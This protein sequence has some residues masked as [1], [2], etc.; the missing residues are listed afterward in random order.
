M[1]RWDEVREGI[2]KFEESPVLNEDLLK[3]MDHV[4]LVD[5]W[6]RRAE[7]EREL[8]GTL[9]HHL[10]G[11]ERDWHQER[12]RNEELERSFEDKRRIW[13]KERE[14]LEERIK[15]REKEIELL[16]E[17]ADWENKFQEAVKKLNRGEGGRRLDS[18]EDGDD[19]F[20]SHELRRVVKEVL[21]LRDTLDQV[22]TATGWLDRE[23]SRFMD[24]L[25]QRGDT[26]R[27]QDVTQMKEVIDK[28]ATQISS[29]KEEMVKKMA[30]G[31]P[32][33]TAAP[34]VKGDTLLMGGV[35][36]QSPIAGVFKK[37]L[38]RLMDFN[39]SQE[40]TARGFC[41]K[42][43]NLL[44]II[45]GTA[46]IGLTDEKIAP[47]MKENLTTIDQN[48]T[49]LL[50]SIEEFLGITKYPQ[51]NFEEVDLNLFVQESSGPGVR[52]ELGSGLP[53]VKVDKNLI[54]DAFTCVVTNARESGA[55]DGSPVVISTTNDEA[56]N[57]VMISVKDSGKGIAENH[58]KKVFQ[59]Y[60]TTKKDQR[61]L[62]LSKARHLISL[63]GG[64]ITIES[65]KGQGTT[66][67]MWIPVS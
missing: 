11:R 12:A 40:D 54:R 51:M 42:A 8:L 38:E 44:G 67:K 30:E 23:K 1:D 61:G 17:R 33:K 4:S 16:R 7:E 10:D 55:S 46:Q 15:A 27:P 24:L 65:I 49:Y 43:R 2:R 14:A 9:R 5:Y 50:Q 18:G 35:S 59:P 64:K 47:E 56:E 36:L 41:H 26:V 28:V 58:F 39:W 25:N 6:K 34:E 57:S 21:S 62:G 13:E 31:V 32:A 66:V 3:A 29:F 60:F 19:I 37:W 45:S 63:H 52:F 20:I 22:Q 48:T 53:K